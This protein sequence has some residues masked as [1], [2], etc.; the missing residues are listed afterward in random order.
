MNKQV[1]ILNKITNETKTI[2]LQGDMNVIRNIVANYLIPEEWVKIPND[3][4]NYGYT[5]GVV[6]EILPPEEHICDIINSKIAG[7]K[8]NHIKYL[9][10]LENETLTLGDLVFSLNSD[11]IDSLKRDLGNAKQLG[12][13][14]IVSRDLN[15]TYFM[16]D[17]PHAEDLLNQVERA[18]FRNWVTEKLSFF[19]KWRLER[20]VKQSTREQIESIDLNIRVESEQVDALLQLSIEDLNNFITNKYVEVS[21]QPIPE[22]PT[23][24]ENTT[25]G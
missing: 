18:K 7:I 4:K 3:K 15:N 1:R 25:N 2:A 14:V 19:D 17:I 10:N 11:Y 16:Y 6:V 13:T 5:D 24:E 20:L 8:Q 12:L 21:G 23:Q 9:E 22:V